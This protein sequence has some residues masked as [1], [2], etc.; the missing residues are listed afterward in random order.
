MN[1]DTE[2]RRVSYVGVNHYQLGNICGEQVLELL[3]EGENRIMMISGSAAGDVGTNL[4]Y[5]QM[6]QVIA[7]G[8]KG[9]SDGE[10]FTYTIEGNTNFDAEEAS[11]IFFVNS[12]SVPDI[13]ICMDTI[14]AECACQA[15][16][17]TTRWEKW[18]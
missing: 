3:E 5:S 1:D 16:V 17:I 15:V 7:P 14:S 4:M 10:D 8:K 6:N 9:G 18:M 2:S 12:Q 13:L 11:G